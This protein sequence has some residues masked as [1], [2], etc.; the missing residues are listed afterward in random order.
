MVARTYSTPQD[1]LLR[2]TKQF[3]EVKADDHLLV[4][5]LEIQQLLALHLT[6]HKWEIDPNVFQKKAEERIE[7][8]FTELIH[9]HNSQEWYLQGAIKDICHAIRDGASQRGEISPEP[10]PGDE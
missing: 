8:I 4:A 7:G 1:E 3:P 10:K 6:N 9:Y 2:I 5:L